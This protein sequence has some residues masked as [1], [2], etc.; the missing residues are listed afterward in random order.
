MYFWREVKDEMVTLVIIDYIL[1]VTLAANI[2]IK[3]IKNMTLSFF[4]MH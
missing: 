4:K 2:N 3:N 1:N